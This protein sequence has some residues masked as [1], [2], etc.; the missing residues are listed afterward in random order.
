[1]ENINKLTRALQKR[2]N[3]VHTGIGTRCG[4]RLLQLDLCK[5]L[6]HNRMVFPLPPS[7][8]FLNSM[9]SLLWVLTR[10]STAL[11]IIICCLGPIS[12]NKSNHRGNELQASQ[13]LRACLGV[14]TWLPF[15]AMA[16]GDEDPPPDQYVKPCQ[17]CYKC[18]SL[19]LK[20]PVQAV[21][22]LF[23]GGHYDECRFRSL[24][25]KKAHATRGERSCLR[26]SWIQMDFI[27]RLMPVCL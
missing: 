11:E 5:C 9:L 20:C 4:C 13:L 6:R 3:T 10:E 2:K 15:A 22:L 7:R 23:L 12:R 17:E 24:A 1:M 21:M 25:R 26:C 8:G 19:C 14:S 27:Q 18:R 16:P